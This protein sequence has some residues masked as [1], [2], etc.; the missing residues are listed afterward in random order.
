[1]ALE[2]ASRAV[3]DFFFRRREAK[4]IEVIP[5]KEGIRG[6]LTALNRKRYLALLGDRNYGKSGVPVRFFDAVSI[7][8][9]GPVILAMKSGAPV[10][11]GFTYPG[12]DRGV[13][14]VFEESI[15]INKTG[16]ME[17]DLVCNIAKIAGLFEKYIRQHT[18]YWFA[19][20]PVWGL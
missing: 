7:F 20:E 14:I 3:T 11:P 4:G 15:E 19:F 8:P 6:C 1:V 18:D 13:Q 17:K 10:I 12:E 9:A 2:H 16:D 5:Y